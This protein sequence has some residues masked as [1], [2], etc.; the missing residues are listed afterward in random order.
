MNFSR[1]RRVTQTLATLIATLALLLMASGGA[2]ASGGGSSPFDPSS[3]PSFAQQT[4]GWTTAQFAAY[5]A[6]LQAVRNFAQA[7]ASGSVRPYICVP[8]CV[9]NFHYASMAIV[10]E[11]SADCACGPATASE[12]Y[13][14]FNYY[15][16]TPSQSL[17]AME[18]EMQNNGWYSCANGTWRTGLMYEMNLHQSANPY[19]LGGI[20]SG[21]DVYNYTAVDLGLYN[22][23]VGYDGETYG[24]YGYPLSNYPAVDWGHYFP[25]YGYDENS[26][27]YVADPHYAY[28][29]AYSATAVF[30][31]IANFSLLSPQVIW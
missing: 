14:T 11:G 16:G 27:V 8:T 19:V 2:F 22:F 18:S 13:S 1:S 17:A 9:P 7:R 25:A 31:F 3:E 24:A 28:D 4:A 26:N 12:M 23:P 21:A 10:W 29:Y 5:T 30:Q 20:S 6:K 15:Y